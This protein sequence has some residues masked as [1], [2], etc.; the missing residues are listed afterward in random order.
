MIRIEGRFE[1][2]LIS[3]T[4]FAEYMK[5]R[6]FTVRSLADRVGCSHSVVGHL[7]SGA[8]KTCH[9][10]TATAIERAL[11]A[12]RGSLFIPHVSHVAREVAPIGA[13]S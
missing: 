6:G 7:R 11:D 4:A 13:A 3:A 2:K 12:P 1:V 10:D 5:Y 8:R 9:P